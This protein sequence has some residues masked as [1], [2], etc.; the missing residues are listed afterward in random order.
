MG[1]FDK[2][3][4]KNE[5]EDFIPKDCSIIEM[6]NYMLA[7]IKKENLNSCYSLSIS[8]LTEISPIAA[9]TANTIK[10]IVENGTSKTNKLYCITNL[11][12]NDSLKAMKDGKTFWGAI[13][14]SDNTSAMAKLKEVN[15]SNLMAL[16]PTIMMMSFALAGI[17]SELGEIKEISKKIL[18]FLQNDKESEIESDL[19]IL[20]RS[21]NDF[22]FNLNDEKY[23]LNNHKQIMDIK[24]TAN[25]NMLFYKKEIEDD[26]VKNKI[27]T[28]SNSMKS[29]IDEIQKKFKYYRLSLYI[30]SFS[31]LMEILLLGNYGSEYLL[32]KKNELD[33]LDE[34]YSKIFNDSLEYIKKNAGKSLESNVLL[35]LGSAGKA[36]GDLVEKVNIK[37]VDTWLNE[38]GDNLRKTGKNIEDNYANKFERV[39][40]TYSNTFSNQIE[41]INIIY[42]NTKEIYFDKDKIY[43]D[44]K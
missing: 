36:I 14:K 16:D 20:N 5:I 24:R 28:T 30:Y 39:K 27:L 23:L 22:R 11:G 8:K 31:T 15:P 26:I 7:D 32:N 10:N 3:K 40:D 44:I 9:P 19:Q 13:K 33:S 1:F 18:S 42:N 37:N 29:I 12:K 17:E 2:I 6:N 35:G 21:I 38:K 43:L 25:K 41:K 4:N 34:E